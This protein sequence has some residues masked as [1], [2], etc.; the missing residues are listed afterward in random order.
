MTDSVECVV[1]SVTEY[2]DED[3]GVTEIGVSV[4]LLT[5]KYESDDESDVSFKDVSFKYC[6]VVCV[7]V[8]A[9]VQVWYVRDWG[10]E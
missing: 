5:F 3:V 9:C 2:E 1:V 8:R 6:S 7:C 4:S 10:N